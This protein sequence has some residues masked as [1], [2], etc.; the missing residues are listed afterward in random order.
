[1]YNATLHT[2][3]KV[4]VF[5]LSWFKVQVTRIYDLKS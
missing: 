4:Q 3:F 2:W 5:D 1:M